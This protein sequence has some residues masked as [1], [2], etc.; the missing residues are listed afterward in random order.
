M[1]DPHAPRA[2][3]CEHLLARLCDVGACID[4]EGLVRVRVS[5]RVRVRVRVRVSVRVRVRVGVRVNV[6]VRGKVEG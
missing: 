6:R 2:E 3:D 1:V 5:V 4:E